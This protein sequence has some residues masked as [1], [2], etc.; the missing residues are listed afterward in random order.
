MTNLEK[1]KKSFAEKKIDK[2]IIVLAGSLSEY[3]DYVWGSTVR[4]KLVYGDRPEVMFGIVAEN[5][6]EIGTFYTLPQS[7][8][9]RDIANSRRRT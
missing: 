2:K 7:Y 6:V 8:L 4:E 1:A 9:L 3:L 5:I